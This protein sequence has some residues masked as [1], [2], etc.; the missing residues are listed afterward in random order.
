MPMVATGL[1]LTVGCTGDINELK[2]VVGGWF[3]RGVK[4]DYFLRWTE[5]SLRVKI[6]AESQ[7]CKYLRNSV[8]YKLIIKKVI[9]CDI[10][11][12]F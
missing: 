11:I 4:V 12:F 6:I 2:G 1:R 7:G 5:S 8:I 3:T 9:Q 10:W